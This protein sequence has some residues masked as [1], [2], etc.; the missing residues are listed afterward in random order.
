M[1]HFLCQILISAISGILAIILIAFIL[2]RCFPYDENHYSQI[3][4]YKIQ[5]L[6]R[7]T[8]KQR[9]ILIGGSNIA[10]GFNS[11]ILADSL[12][13]DVINMGITAGIGLKGMLDQYDPYTKVGDIVIIS[14]EYEHFYNRFAYG[15]ESYSE[16]C[17]M[18]DFPNITQMNLQQW[19]TI[20]MH[21]PA[22]IEAA[23]NSAVYHKHLTQEEKDSI[24]SVDIH[25]I[26]AFNQYGDVVRHWEYDKHALRTK[27]MQKQPL[28][29]PNTCFSN[30]LFKYIE[31]LKQKGVK[32]MFYPPSL[33][34]SAY[35]IGKQEIDYVGN[36][37]R[38]NNNAFICPLTELIYPDTLFYDTKY[39][40][41][42]IG[43]DRRTKHLLKLLQNNIK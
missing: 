25:Q 5:L 28:D 22:N 20:V 9:I 15:E 33:C 32:V 39:H 34:T 3:L 2:L 29:E 13:C 1:K 16:L 23:I 38:E 8:S 35:D 11:Q 19:Q 26:S 42:K 12:D 14:P 21:T 4:S 30:W 43:V 27:D 41:R 36:L 10:F 40:L 37:L 6:E 7:E 17:Y 31:S 24:Y 18:H